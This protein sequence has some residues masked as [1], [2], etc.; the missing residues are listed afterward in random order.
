MTKTYSNIKKLKSTALSLLFVAAL[1]QSAL[2]MAPKEDTDIATIKIQKKKN[3]EL[4]K[5]STETY[6]NDRIAILPLPPEDKQ[7]LGKDDSKLYRKNLEKVQNVQS[8]VREMGITLKLSALIKMS[9]WLRK[10][11]NVNGAMS[12]LK[13]ASLTG[14][15]DAIYA[16]A[17][18]L[19]EGHENQQERAFSLFTKLHQLKDPRGTLS[20]AKCYENGWGVIRDSDTALK[21]YRDLAIKNNIIAMERYGNLLGYKYEDKQEEAFQWLKK[22]EKGGNLAASFSLVPFYQGER[23]LEK[24]EKELLQCLENVVKKGNLEQKKEVAGHYKQLGLRQRNSLLREKAINLYGELAQKDPELQSNYAFEIW[25]YGDDLWQG[26]AIQKNLQKAEKLIL[27]AAKAG[28]EKALNFL[29]KEYYQG[30]EN[31]KKF[32]AHIDEAAKEGHQYAIEILIEIY[33]EGKFVSKDMNKV[34]M[35]HGI[36]VKKHNNWSSQRKLRELYPIH[37]TNI[38]KNAYAA[39]YLGEQIGYGNVPLQDNES[40]DE[41]AFLMYKASADLGDLGAAY[42]TGSAYRRGN[43]VAV[44]FKK[45]IEYLQKAAKGEDAAKVE[46]AG[47]YL[48]E[49]NDPQA[50]QKAATI[51]MDAN[52]DSHGVLKTIKRILEAVAQKKIEIE[53]EDHFYYILG[54]SGQKDIYYYND[55]VDDEKEVNAN[56]P[57]F[58]FEKAVQVA[59]KRRNGSLI[60]KIADNYLL[61]LDVKKNKQKAKS[62]YEKAVNFGSVDALNKL[63]EM[64]KIGNGLK[65]DLKKAQDLLD[66]AQALTGKLWRTIP[67]VLSNAGQVRPAKSIIA[68]GNN[69]EVTVKTD[70]SAPSLCQIRTLDFNVTEGNYKVSCG[71]KLGGTKGLDFAVFN[72]KTNG[73][74]TELPHLKIGEYKVNETFA[75]PKDVTNLSVV[76]YTKEK[77]PSF[78]F[79]LKDLK[80]EKEENTK[81][82]SMQLDKASKSRAAKAIVE[83]KNREIIVTTSNVQPSLCQLESNIFDVNEGKIIYSYKIT[84]GKGAAISLGFLA[85]KRNMWLSNATLALKEGVNQGTFETVVPKEVKQTS[86][87]LFNTNKSH[88]S[89]KFTVH[90]GY[91]HNEE[92]KN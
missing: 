37:K 47:L 42:K 81:L 35:Y 79:T 8:R 69:G 33:E 44:D 41:Q 51:M 62:L 86:L 31:C 2:G 82:I 12:L 6:F 84:L 59:E 13:Q 92:R 54:S 26:H 18:I 16:Y 91:V 64:Y 38:M 7:K 11:G 50:L 63:A 68:R 75:V 19:S 65:Q 85:P 57:D 89:P 20:L 77:G 83:K 71:L 22:A 4:M 60:V 24:N 1:S 39:F 74:L 87:V 34:I 55:E 90:Y 76:F 14:N 10:D 23:N 43:G 5:K 49:Q 66:E 72:P 29:K 58:Q 73:W 53:Q 36:L 9:D 15:L 40:N 45:A 48:N 56:T 21:F 61:G 80:I 52:V 25:D 3:K 70:C 32:L 27:D 46:L 28:S 30:K 67:A 88:N 17:N 78:D